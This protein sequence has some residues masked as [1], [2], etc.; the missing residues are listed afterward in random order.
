MARCCK[1][2]FSPRALRLLRGYNSS[3]ELPDQSLAEFIEIYED[4]FGEK[5]SRADA[6]NMAY[7]LVSLYET[8]A[9]KLPSEQTP[10]D[11]TPRDGIAPKGSTLPA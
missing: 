3:V 5:L 7:D 9:R 2:K 11:P 8:L 6:F 4:E 10:G 1:G